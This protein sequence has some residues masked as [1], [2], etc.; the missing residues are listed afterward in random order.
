MPGAR[1]RELL[2]RG[3]AGGHAGGVLPFVCELART[4]AWSLAA[5]HLLLCARPTRS[6]L[7]P[8][9]NPNLHTFNSPSVHS[10]RAWA[11]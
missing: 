11:S 4:G 1:P 9:G 5:G 8:S 10:C 6:T 2:E 7:P 3:G